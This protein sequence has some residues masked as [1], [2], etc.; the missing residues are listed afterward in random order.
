MQNILALFQL[1]RQ[2]QNALLFCLLV[3][4]LFL[5]SSQCFNWRQGILP[6][7]PS[8]D[9]QKTA[10]FQLNLNQT[11]AA[12]LSVLPGIGPVLSQRIIDHRNEVGA[13]LSVESLQDVKGIGPKRLR[14]ISRYLTI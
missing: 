14:T 9:F 4:S 13:F 2:D 8:S 3:G 11:T 6:V 7:L 10:E 1:K 5:F 12:E